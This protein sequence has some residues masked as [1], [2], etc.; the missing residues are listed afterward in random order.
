LQ[1][2]DAILQAL[3]SL[4][5]DHAPLH[6]A[7]N[8]TLRPKKRFKF[9]L[10]WLKLEGFEDAIKEAWRC[11]DAITDPFRRLD[12][13]FRNAAES[14]Q[15][16]GQRKTGNVKLQSQTQSYSDLTLPKRGDCYRQGRDGSGKRL[17]MQFLG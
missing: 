2:P 12:A 6:L 10:F 7:F 11:D 8:A 17:S 4:A 1:N 13:L 15:S 16:W 9:E 14:L 5:L 3:L